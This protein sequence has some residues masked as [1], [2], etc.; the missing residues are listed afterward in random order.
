MSS[1]FSSFSK[2]FAAGLFLAGV[3][4]TGAAQE[5][6][7]GRVLVQFKPNVGQA[8]AQQILNSIGGKVSREIPQLGMKVVQLPAGANENAMRE[9]LSK[10][11]EV[12]AASLDRIA[13]PALQPNDPLFLTN[14]WG[15]SRIR[16]MDAWSLTTGSPSVTIAIL[17]TGVNTSHEDLASKIVPGW[18]VF[19]NTS[20]VSDGNG[21][22]TMVAGT[23]AALGNNGRGVA[24]V[25]WG[26]LVMPIR[27]TGDTGSSSYSVIANGLVWAADRGARVANIS[28]AP[29]NP[30][31][32][33]LANGIRYFESKGGVVVGAAGNTGATSTIQANPLLLTVSGTVSD[34]SLAAGST[35]G[36]LVDL[37]APWDTTT[38]NAGGGY[39]SGGGTSFSTP[40]VSGAAALVLS[41]NP[42]LTPDQVKQV[43]T[44]TVDDLGEPGWDPNFGWGR[45][46]VGRAVASAMGLLSLDLSPPSVLFQQPTNNSTL[47]GTVNLAATA[48]DNVGVTRVDFLLN[49]TLLGSSSQAP[50]TFAWNSASAT[51]GNYSLQAVAWD[52]AGNSGAHTLNVSVRNNFDTVAPSVSITSPTGGTFGNSLSVSVAASDNVAVRRVELWV[53]GKLT[54]TDT[55][56]AW[57]FSVNTRKWAAGSYTLQCRA[58]DDAGNVG[59]SSLVTVRK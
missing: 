53:N 29:L 37:S 24:G 27:I 56:P 45:L 50:Y 34:D 13:R 51:D 11:T 7:P 59:H 36:A 33:T 55:S 2:S 26:A 20:N 39:S 10:L 31:D 8:R 6:V 15:P 42:N 21:H 40:Y 12:S 47:T 5:F 18:N 44:Q 17:D 28:F 22:G 9:R 38:T 35:R 23:A 41:A 14:Q 19:N 25:A 54:A 16:A 58:Y 4:G 48:S 52:A 43:L 1:R 32:W 57:S 3:V 49:G 46:N 30:A